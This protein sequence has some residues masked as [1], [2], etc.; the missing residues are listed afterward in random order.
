MIVSLYAAALALLFVFLAVRTILARVKHGTA[1]G[2]G[3]HHELQRAIRAHAHF[4]EYVPFSLLLI[5]ML[6]LQG[7]NHYLLH[8]LGITLAI[9]R[10][11]HAYSLLKCE[12]YENGQIIVSSMKFRQLGMFLSFGVIGI[13][14]VALLVTA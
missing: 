1:L 9:G 10:L 3:G 13:S 11:L 8:G 4:A 5:L 2:D 12:T 7:S 14:A 6:E